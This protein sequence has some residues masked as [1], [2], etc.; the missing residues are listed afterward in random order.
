MTLPTDR[1]PA[2]DTQTAAQTDAL[3]G[4]RALDRSLV[5]GIAWT[6]GAKWAVQI[7]SWASTLIVARL[8]T[9]ADYGLFGMAMVFLGIVEYIS[10]FGIGAAIIQGHDLAPQHIARLSGFSVAVGFGS[11]AL[12]AATAPLIAA[13]F[14]EP[15]LTRVIIVLGVSFVFSAFRAVPAALM[16]R[17]LQFRR[18]AVAETSEAVVLILLTL[19]MAAAGQHYW[20]L[21]IGMVGSRF[22]GAVVVNTMRPQPMAFPSPFADIAR[23]VRFGAYVVV[24]SL[25]WYA[26]GNADRVVLGR[27]LGKVALGDYAVGFNLASAPLEKVTQLY[28]RVSAAVIARV[29]KDTAEVARYLLRITEGVAIVTFP[30]SVGMALVAH[31]FVLVVLGDRWIDAVGPLRILSLAAALRSLDPLLAQ[32]LIATGNAKT[33]ARSMIVAMVVLT[34]AF[35][36]GAQ[37]GITGVALVWLIGHPAVVMTRQVWAALKVS[38]AS[39]ADYLRAL[40]PATSSVTL[41]AAAVLAAQMAFSDVDSNAALLVIQVA[42]GVAAYSVALLALHRRRVF[43][44]RDFVLRRA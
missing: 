37:W 34:P 5:S 41:M 43:A 3:S 28:Q 40:W 42:T 29:Q 32:L 20:A 12:T 14:G 2:E 4:R 9:P 22:V 27:L 1:G 17:D 15:D 21:I 24:S 10:E 36:L 7:V 25:A 19:G 18:L 35:I 39:L 38:R 30:L 8:L 23:S 13:F 33:N 26:Y 6:G 16:S 44:A 11:W 31:E